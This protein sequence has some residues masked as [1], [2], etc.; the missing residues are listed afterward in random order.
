MRRSFE[1]K[2][3]RSAYHYFLFRFLCIL[4][5]TCLSPQVSAEPAPEK[6]L[7]SPREAGRIAKDAASRSLSFLHR[8][9]E[10][11]GKKPWESSSCVRPYNQRSD[12]AKQPARY[13]RTA[14]A[15]RLWLRQRGVAK[16]LE[17]IE[18][19]ERGKILKPRDLF[20]NPRPI[21]VLPTGK[22]GLTKKGQKRRDFLFSP[23]L[24]SLA[25]LLSPLLLLNG[26]ALQPRGG[27]N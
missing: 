18:L 9:T 16:K 22:Y 21:S 5:L 10:D 13:L 20:D 23:L 14:K 4:V 25:L 8:E 17:P 3:R 26:V 11:R 24:P 2:C 27:L 15:K 6:R 1:S 12:S 19:N 7:T